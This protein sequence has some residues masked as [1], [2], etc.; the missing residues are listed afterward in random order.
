MAGFFYCSWHLKDSPASTRKSLKILQPFGLNLAIK[1][2]SFTKF[3]VLFYFC[4][5]AIRISKHLPQL[6]L[7]SKSHLQPFSA[8]A[9]KLIILIFGRKNFV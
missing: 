6:N 9:Y 4:S 7:V 2:V 1:G 8:K 5:S 3:P